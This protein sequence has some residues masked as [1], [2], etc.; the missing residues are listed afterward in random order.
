M[1]LVPPGRPNISPPN[2]VANI[3]WCSLS[4]GV[5]EMRVAALTLPGAEAVERDGEV[6]DA[7][8]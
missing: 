3:H 5:T 4:T 1:P 6:M 2:R 8:E 7:G